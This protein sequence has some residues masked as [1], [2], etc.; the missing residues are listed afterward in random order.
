MFYTTERNSHNSFQNPWKEGGW[1]GNTT[2][3]Y[4][5][6]HHSIVIEVPVQ[7]ATSWKQR[8]YLTI[9]V[10]RKGIII[11]GLKSFRFALKPLIEVDLKIIF[12]KVLWFGHYKV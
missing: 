4:H 11:E 7:K 8:R 10:E 2:N 5:C 3:S 6:I 12:R 1:C 9:E